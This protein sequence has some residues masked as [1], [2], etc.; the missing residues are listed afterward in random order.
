M[1]VNFEITTDRKFLKRFW[2]HNDIFKFSPETVEKLRK[3]D[4]PYG[5]YGYG[6]WLY[7]VRPDG[8]K[9]LRDARKC[10]E[11]ASENGVADAKQML[12][13][14]LFMGDS[15]NEDKGGIW[16]KK[17][18]YGAHSQCPSSR[19]RKCAGFTS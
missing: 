18:C 1:A 15:Y 3:S 5:K 11:Y 13:Y 17:Q 10:F 12:S 4:N 8:D 9:S 7:R 6:Q 2:D 14:M 16:G 19:R